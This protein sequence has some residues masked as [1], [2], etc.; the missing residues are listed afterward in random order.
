MTL[1]CAIID[2]E[3]LAVELLASYAKKTPFLNLTGAYNSAVEAI[4]DLK[5]QPVDLIFLDIQMPE[6]SG[7]EFARIL[8]R[9]TKI[10]F[11]TAFDKYATEGYKVDALYYLLKPIAY[12]D[13]I[14]AANKALDCFE[15]LKKSDVYQQD[16]FLFVKSDYKLIRIPLDDIL[17]IE[18]VKDYIRITLE[19]GE[20]IMSLMNMK[21]LEDFLPHP[22]F[23]RTHRSFIVHMNKVPVVDRLRM[24]FGTTYIP[25]SE[26]YKDTVLAYFDKHTLG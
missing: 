5:A 7:L 12:E 20:K 8:P 3:P 1:N 22:E 6:L 19:N 21:K 18:G 24:V 11:T 2:D 14:K 26:S 23:L 15:R 10:V 25:I 13:F 9:E 4:K 16:R 17:Y